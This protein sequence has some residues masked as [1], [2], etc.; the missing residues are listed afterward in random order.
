M[1]VPDQVRDDGP[2]IQLCYGLAKDCGEPVE[3]RVKPGMTIWKYLWFF[4]LRL[5]LA[6][7]KPA[8]MVLA[9]PEVDCKP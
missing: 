9:E 5:T 6:G 3:P 8:R 7:G 1:P 2:G 4:K